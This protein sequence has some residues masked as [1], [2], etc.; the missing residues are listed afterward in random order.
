MALM[1]DEI[2]NEIETETL[3]PFLYKKEPPEF[4]PSAPWKHDE[5]ER[6]HIAGKLNK[7]IAPIRQPFVM[8]LCGRYGSGKTTFAQS[9]R[10]DLENNGTKTV[11]FNAWENDYSGDAFA[12]FVH[13]VTKAMG[14]DEK[15]DAIKKK[16]VKVGVNILRATGGLALRAGFRV[17][18]GVNADKFIENLG[19][20]DD[21]MGQAL[22][23]IVKDSFQA[24]EDT[25]ISLIAFKDLLKNYIEEECAGRLIIFVDEL[26]RC[27][28][29]YAI[30]VLERI[31][32]VFD[33]K[34]IIFV[35]CVDKQ[36][37]LNSISGVYGNKLD[38]DGYYRKFVDHD[39]VL[40]SPSEG[41]YVRHLWKN[42][43]DFQTLFYEKEDSYF[44][45]QDDV[46]YFVRA[47]VNKYGL[48]LRRIDQLFTRL[49]LSLRYPSEWPRS[50]IVFATILMFCEPDKYW[51]MIDLDRNVDTGRTY[52]EHLFSDL[53]EELLAM[54]NK[55]P[56]SNKNYFN[57]KLSYLIGLASVNPEFGQ[58]LAVDDLWYEEQFEPSID[59]VVRSNVISSAI[60]FGGLNPTSALHRL[61][62]ELELQST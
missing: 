2:P 26:D 30:E 21:D 36:Q 60:R 22:E 12:A 17:A 39:Y 46:I 15:V 1:T 37:L 5:L 4:D 47:F 32:H 19:S 13:A 42:V 14:K 43:F 54:V 10:H 45:H 27:R 18:T 44:R 55:N 34:G 9:W 16:A 20:S 3:L 57:E 61:T 11:Y 49:N 53:R 51:E 50:F 52:L 23:D 6:R 38:A 8:M 41:R 62:K 24:H 29:N 33:V 58:K 31:K 35:L 59:N 28:P 25:E 56:S 7:I 48:S 40:P